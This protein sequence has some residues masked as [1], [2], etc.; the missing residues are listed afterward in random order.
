MLKIRKHLTD[1]AVEIVVK[2]YVQPSVM[3]NCLANLKLNNTQINKLKSISRRITSLSSTTVIDFH[4]EIKKHAAKI[5]RKCIDKSVCE[6]FHNYFKLRSHNLNTRNN[7][8]SIELPKCR[9]E[10]SKC[11][12]YYMGARIYNEL[13]REIREVEGEKFYKVLKSF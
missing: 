9:L 13:P 1:D 12:F 7:N 4:K 5:V 6:N 3:F 11:S 8:I 2:S 10:F